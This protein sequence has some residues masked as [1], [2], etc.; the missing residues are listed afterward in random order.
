MASFT[1]RVFGE[2][3]MSP[4]LYGRRRPLVGADIEL[5]ALKEDNTG[6]LQRILALTNPISITTNDHGRFDHRTD[7][8]TITPQGV[9]IPL[10][11]PDAFRI[12][13]LNPFTLNHIQLGDV[14]SNGQNM[15][16][17]SQ[18]SP[19][20]TEPLAV[21]QGKS[22]TDLGD[23]ARFLAAGLAAPQ[24]LAEVR[25]PRVFLNSKDSLSP[26]APE[27]LFHQFGI[28]LDRLQMQALAHRKQS[29]GFNPNNYT[30]VV[31][32]RPATLEKSIRAAIS[33]YPR[34]SPADRIAKVV[35]GY[36]GTA[37]DEPFLL[38]VLPR[39]V[40]ILGQILGIPVNYRPAWYLW[41]DMAVAL[42]L[43]TGIGLVAQGNRIVCAD[44]VNKSDERELTL[45]TL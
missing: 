8:G 16:I 15:Y 35:S 40:N 38:R 18:I 36:G 42:T 39:L 24:Q 41:E 33:W 22:F 3:F 9:P 23:L 25:L 28:M 11:T 30:L 6:Q 27:Q 12:D 20:V 45:S 34:L 10:P 26:T 2:V 37:N 31:P 13:V 1:L 29:P 43:L 44:Y 7:W 4:D 17:D 14:F 5:M 32:V 19:P 21:A